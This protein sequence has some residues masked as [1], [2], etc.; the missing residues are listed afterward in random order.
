[1]RLGRTPSAAAVDGGEVRH[2]QAYAGREYLGEIVATDCQAQA[3]GRD[4]EALGTFPNLKAASA[5]I[6]AASGARRG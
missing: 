6:S 2:L 3:F 4:G 1:V 5:A